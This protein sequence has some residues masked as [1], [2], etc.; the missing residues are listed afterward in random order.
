MYKYEMHCHTAEGSKCG[1]ATGAEMADFYKS[2][3]YSGL[4]IS[5]HFFN[6]N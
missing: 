3:G 2:M 6:G 4:V 5:D 1:R